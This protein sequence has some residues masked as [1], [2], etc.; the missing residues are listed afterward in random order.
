[1]NC[2]VN[3]QSHSSPANIC[4]SLARL[5][6]NSHLDYVFTA[7]GEVCAIANTSCCTWINTSSQV[8]LETMNLLNL[9]RSLKG[10]SCFASRVNGYLGFKFSDIFS[11]LPKGLRDVLRSGLQ[12]VLP[13]V[14]VICSIYFIAKLLMFC[15]TKCLKPTKT[16]AWQVPSGFATSHPPSSH[17]DPRSETQSNSLPKSCSSHT[18]PGLVYANTFGH[19]TSDLCASALLK[20]KF[21]FHPL[22]NL[23]ASTPPIERGC[24][25]LPSLDPW[26]SDPV[27][28]A[29]IKVVIFSFIPL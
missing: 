26:G 5:I 13:I 21:L 7:Q 23:G 4:E 16:Q 8:E 9:D 3:F 15:I 27:A 12:I 22:L 18:L 14:I 20:G 17:G 19:Q 11:W 24:P 1:M 25:V 29:H 6:L 28:K 10:H 2:L